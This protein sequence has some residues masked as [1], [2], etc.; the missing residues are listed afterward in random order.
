MAGNH[1]Q[2][3]PWKIGEWLKFLEKKE[4][5]DDC[6][7]PIWVDGLAWSPAEERS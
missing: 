2:R 1:R 6:K 5:A 4:V 3:P 7:R